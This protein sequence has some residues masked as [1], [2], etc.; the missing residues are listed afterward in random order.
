M[1]AWAAP[2]LFSQAATL[3]GIAVAHSAFNIACTILLF[4]LSGVLEKIAYLLIPEGESVP[5]V[6]KLDSR[7]LATP[8]IALER[9]HALSVEMA[10]AAVGA[11]SD[12]MECV[13]SYSGKRVERVRELEEFT[14]QCEDQISDYLIQLSAGQLTQEHSNQAAELLK[15]TG[16]LERIADHAL[17]VVESAQEIQKKEITFTPELLGELDNIRKALRAI[18]DLTQQAFAL[19]DRE[20]AYQVKALE[21]V[22]DELKERCRTSHIH[23][24][25]KGRCSVE[26][27]FV[28]SDILTDLERAADHCDNIAR[29]V[30]CDPQHLEQVPE[31]SPQARALA[32]F[33]QEYLK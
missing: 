19:E 23:R 25:Q 12:A 11:M 4:P 5:K 6:E 33:R 10:A 1:D 8:A 20:A 29:S 32:R 24:L 2:A 31:Q 13:S 18:L 17:N 14:D 3:S 27:G 15:I 7:L 22:I 9:A 21:Q 16:D 26:A 28:W 30:L